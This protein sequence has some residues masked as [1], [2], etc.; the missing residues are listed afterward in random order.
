MGRIAGWKYT[1]HRPG[2]ASLIAQDMAENPVPANSF[3]LDRFRLETARSLPAQCFDDFQRLTRTLIYGPDFQW[4]LVDAR[5]EVLR[6]QVME[7][8]DSV[9]SAAG[10]RVKQVRLDPGITDVSALET[11]LVENAAQAEVVHV[12][13]SPGW[14]D[15]PRWDAFNVR[16]ERIATQARARLVF[17]LDADAIALAS[18]GAPDLWA[19]RSGVYVFA[20][21]PESGQVG[22]PALA[23][24]PQALGIP[25]LDNRNKT[26]RYRRLG[27][28]KSWLEAHP[29]APD[30][31]QGNLL[32]ELGELLF[33]L[34]DYDAALAHWEQVALTFH[35]S[36]GANHKVAA[37]RGKIAD[38]L[39]VRGQLDEALRIRREEQLPVYECLGDV[40]AYAITQSKIA[41]ILQ[42]RGQ[43]DEALHIQQEELLSVFERLDDIHSRAMTHGKIADILQTRG[44]LDEALRIR[45]EEELPVYERLDDLRSRAIAQG[46]IA[47][48]LQ[49]RGQL[50]EA[51]HIRREEELP[52]YERLGDV[53]SRATAQGNIA[54][55]LQERGQLEEALHIRRE[56]EL[57]VYERLGE[58]RSCAI[59]QGQI[60]DLLQK[61]GRLD[62]ALCI[63]RDE[64][65]P[66]YQRLGD[67]R[68]LAIC[69]VYIARTLQAKNSH[70]IAE[71]LTL[72]QEAWKTLK[73]LGSPEA[74][75]VEQELR[76]VL[77]VA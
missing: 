12:I 24:P 55:I 4:L 40:R 51:L 26:E 72:L 9:L 32:Y 44:Q 52:V 54:D 14:F 2:S 31:M 64:E 53:R 11:L 62:E 49:E 10:L 1:A 23:I 16:R 43:V 37:V 71:V 65:L 28:I 3:E 76:A 25:G 68:S 60:A 45:R 57:P 13:G 41:D 35:Q 5:H 63:R 21:Q 36:M 56:E 46:K 74:D 47:D 39:E 7:A 59:A 58:V 38:I 22:E 27:E 18:Q 67:M 42:I 33:D 66:V 70:Q 19:W 17:W 15:A 29:D 34:G 8:L 30:D 75:W 48:I 77:G 61:L 50:D 69:Q 20:P 6:R 73:Q